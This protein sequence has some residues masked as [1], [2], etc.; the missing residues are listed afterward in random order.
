MG[1]LS[2]LAPWF[3]AGAAAVAVPVIL[4]MLR[5]EQTPALAFTA[6]RFL[7][8]APREQQRRRELRDIWL[9]L[10]RMLAL[11]VLAL[12]FARPYIKSGEAAA[13]GIT[14][15][16]LDTSFSM[17]GKEQ[18]ERA[19]KAALSLVSSVPAGD[20]VAAMAFDDRA[21]LISPAAL[22]R[23][24]ARAAFN[25]LTPNAG[26]TNYAAL[27]ASSARVFGQVGG[28]LIVVTDLQRSGWTTE[29]VL[30]ANVELQV[31]D[32][33]GPQDNIA[34][35]SLKRDANVAAAVVSNYGTKTRSVRVALA[36][37]DKPAGQSAVNLEPG[38]S[39]TVR[40]AD[41]TL[42]ATGVAKVT[43]DDRQGLAAD[44]ERYLVLD[45]PPQPSVLLLTQREDGE[46]AFYLK[47]A[48]QAVDGPRAFTV[49]LV[50]ASERN[51]LQPGRLKTHAVVW[52]MGT[53]GLDR[54]IREQIATYVQEGG[55]LLVT[56]GPMLDPSSFA[57]LFEQ[58]GKLKIESAE[59]TG[60]PTT[61][62]PVDTRHPIFA[63]FGTFAA[64][65]GQAEF[66]QALRIATAADS[67][68]RVVARFTNGLPALV[69]QEI[70]TG[71]VIVFASDVSSEWNDFPRQP[72]FVPFVNET[73]R[74]LANL[75]E[76][77]RD[78]TVGTLAA[79]VAGLPGG[80][81]GTSKPGV[82]KLGNPE[83]LVAVNVDARE[84]RPARM[85]DSE[86]TQMVR[87]TD[88]EGR[89]AD[90]VAREQE[91]GQH[92]WRYGLL[93][94]MGV[95]VAEGLM[96]RRP[97]PAAAGPVEVATAQ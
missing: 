94:L 50:K 87:K 63:A 24:S 22:E 62:A 33:A 25:S 23:G 10:L 42:P 4:H 35:E 27:L 28:K 80:G 30:P 15:V 57:S 48:V 77:P 2:F 74:Y 82:I 43:I 55:A 5:R 72:T 7:R 58:A 45:A 61:L 66:T 9:L 59:G 37:N 70:G 75:R 53:R 92:W 76:R 26:A 91:S 86:F 34:I 64:N 18:F 20:R 96:A 47:E 11:I 8:Q 6:V 40:F 38:A 32:V 60:F 14:V 3:L 85:T 65:L 16:A 12:A 81:S 67:N 39:E 83:R 56:A 95:L 73:L 19:R 46:D 78:L 21:A 97:A 31:V 49:D 54:R 84:S 1:A 69:E 68:S 29:G 13:S 71:R 44:N 93:L 41:V 90:I 52:L 79:G 17:S 88:A 51:N 89:S 36:L